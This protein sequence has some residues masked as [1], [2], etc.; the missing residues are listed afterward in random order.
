MFLIRQGVMREL[1]FRKSE[2]SVVSVD[3][4]IFF[5]G[6]LSFGRCRAVSYRGQG[7]IVFLDSYFELC[8]GQGYFEFENVFIG[9]QTEVEGLQSD[10]CSGFGISRGV[11]GVFEEEKQG[12]GILCLSEYCVLWG[13]EGLVDRVR[14][15]G[16]FYLG[17]M[18]GEQVGWGLVGLDAGCFYL[19]II[20]FGM[21]GLA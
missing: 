1:S 4:G 3:V 10:S 13:L 2:S 5:F 21:K 20:G 18:E 16:W 14:R 11:R 7:S 17:V 12:K 8:Q 15:G 9:Q 19:S 6:E